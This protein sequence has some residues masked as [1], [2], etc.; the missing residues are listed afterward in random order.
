M[1][2]SPSQDVGRC[3]W[4][5]FLF[6]EPLDRFV[7]V[8]FGRFE[9]IQILVVRWHDERSSAHIYPDRSGVRDPY[10]CRDWRGELSTVDLLSTIKIFDLFAHHVLATDKILDPRRAC[11]LS[12]NCGYF[13]SIDHPTPSWIP[14]PGGNW[15]FPGRTP[16]KISWRQ[17]SK[18]YFIAHCLCWVM[19]FFFLKVEEFVNNRKKIGNNRWNA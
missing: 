12:V 13:L 10:V 17:Y 14:K 19:I 4:Y 1:R 3:R 11:T 6:D 8:I 5:V 18:P 9:D 16:V 7:I 2:H 15:I